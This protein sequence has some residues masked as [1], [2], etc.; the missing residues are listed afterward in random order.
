MLFQEAN[1]YFVIFLRLHKRQY[2]M[3]TVVF[4]QIFGL[5]PQYTLEVY[6]RYS[7]V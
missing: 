1:F 5:S 7:L 2:P 3:F 6:C 4:L